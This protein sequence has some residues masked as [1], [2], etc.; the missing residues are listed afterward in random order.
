MAFAQR[1]IY[2]TIEKRDRKLI[3]R[4]N[5]AGF[6]T[7]YAEDGAG[8]MMKALRSGSGYYIDVGACELIANSA[9]KVRSG[10]E[11]VEDPMCIV[12]Q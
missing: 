5:K 3:S 7:D 6:A 8:L 10:V 12:V 9:V 2:K 4:L 11:I 1:E